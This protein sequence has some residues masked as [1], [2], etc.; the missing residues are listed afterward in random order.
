M[1]KDELNIIRHSIVFDGE[2][3][4]QNEEIMFNEKI[5]NL[6]LNNICIPAQ[7]YLLLIKEGKGFLYIKTDKNFQKYD[8]S[9]R[10]ASIDAR[11]FLINNY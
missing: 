4:Y 5:R 6:V 8:F 2:K 1:S 10:D 3:E 9:L 7:L 11:E